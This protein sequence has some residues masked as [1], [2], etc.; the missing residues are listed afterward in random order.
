MKLKIGMFVLLVMSFS[1]QGRTWTDLKGR[2]IEA[3]LIRV[4]GES[5]ILRRNGVE[6]SVKIQ[7]LS[8]TDQEFIKNGEETTNQSPPGLTLAGKP[9]EKGGKMNLVE[10]PFSPDTIKALSR[11]RGNRQDTLKLAVSVPD[12]FDPAKPQKIFV[13]VTAVNNEEEKARG[14]IG[15]FGMYGNICTKLGWVCIAIDS[16]IGDPDGDYAMEEAFRLLTEEWPGIESSVFVTGGFSG[17]AKGC[18]NQACWLMKQKYNVTGV[19][20]AGCNEDYSERCRQ[21]KRSSTSR[22]RKVRVFL[23]MG[24]ADNIAT[25]KQSENVLSSLK[26]NGI[27][28]QRSA[29]HPGGHSL[30]EPHF[31]QAL[32]WFAEPF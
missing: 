29:V 17:G 3:D 28:K 31:E 23:S 8:E 9:L 24:K 15:K 30:H 32:K 26:S 14:N 22:F 10:K 25:I 20:M 7:S 1:V 21:E 18:W 12:D 16:N 19:F 2:T 13:V 27:R 6:M 4:E 5:V 11:I